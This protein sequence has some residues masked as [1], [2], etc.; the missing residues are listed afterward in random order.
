MHFEI[1]AGKR[2]MR[3]SKAKSA[4]IIIN[5]HLLFAFYRELK[6]AFMCGIIDDGMEN[7]RQTKI[8]NLIG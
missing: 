4:K 8:F 6:F 3:I 2:K 7:C 1:L 5:M